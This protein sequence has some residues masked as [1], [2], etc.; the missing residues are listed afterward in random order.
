MERKKKL[1]QS[2]I[3][4]VQYRRVPTWCIAIA[5][6]QGG[7]AMAFYS[8]VGLMSYVASEGYGIALAVAG[9]IL[10]ATRWF[11]GLI[12]PFL[13][14]WIDKL[15]TRFG[16]LRILMLLGLTIRSIAMLML[17]VWFSGRTDNVV[18]FIVLYMVNIVGNSIFDIAGNMLPAVMTNDPR[19]RPTVQVWATIYNYIFPTVLA[20]VSV[21]I[22]LPMFGNQY[23]REML[24][25]T[26]IINVT[27][28]WVLTLIACIGLTPV[29]KPENFMGITA[30]GDDVSLKDMGKFLAH[31]RPFQMYVIAAVSDKLAQQVNS[32]TIVS[33]LLFGILI[34]NIQFGT[35]LSTFSMLPS[36]VFA[37]FGARYCG[38]HGSR[39]ATVT[40]TWV[41]TIVAVISVVFCAAIDM[42]SIS[43]NIVLTVVFFVLLLL[44]NGAKMCVTTANG[45]MR[46]DIVDFE[47]DRSGKYIP[48]IVTATYN[49]IDQLVSSL[50]VTI[51]TLC[52]AAIGYVN[53]VPQ[54]TDAATPAIKFMALFLC[55]GMPLLGWICTLIAM[56][57]YKLTKQELVG[58]QKRIA[59]KKAAVLAEKQK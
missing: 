33:T 13:A 49:F 57:F 50:G 17:F 8:L 28:A 53:T 35:L 22:I 58:V 21:M 48:G 14:V 31:N 46:A 15:H 10:T 37:I 42:R 43:T 25:L 32:Q 38:K 30:G 36:I 18:L 51:A 52:V 40:W 23:T 55:F 41:C 26:C 56:R 11:D 1:S 59:E 47:L 12:D 4:G 24:S 6:M 44:M 39:E 3:D 29:D 5:E 7:A 34:G 16:K 2:E 54:P 20:I 45:S 19:Q 27:V 9:V